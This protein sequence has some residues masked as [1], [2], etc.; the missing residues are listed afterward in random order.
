MQ[1]RAFIVIVKQLNSRPKV[2]AVELAQELGVSVRTV[3]RY[4]DE[5][6]VSGIPIDSQ[7]GCYGGFS[8]DKEY[9]SN[10]HKIEV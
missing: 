6:T 10:K 4:L 7:R 2:T 1:G 9:K 5:L 3:Y 8:L